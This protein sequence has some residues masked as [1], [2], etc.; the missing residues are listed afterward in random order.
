M[1]DLARDYDSKCNWSHW[2]I[3][4]MHGKETEGSRIQRKNPDHP[5]HPDHSTVKKSYNTNKNYVDLKKFA[6]TQIFYIHFTY[7]VLSAR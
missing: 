4:R 7:F 3:P 5:G 1:L 2:Y 6:V